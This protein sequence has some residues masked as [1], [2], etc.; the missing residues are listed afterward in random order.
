MEIEAKHEGDARERRMRRYAALATAL[1]LG[2][3]VWAGVHLA[4]QAH[5][6]WLTAPASIA[7]DVL[8]AIAWALA[9]IASAT[10]LSRLALAALGGCAA[11][12]GLGLLMSVSIPFSGVPF[13]ALGLIE[14]FAVF[15]AMP[16]FRRSRASVRQDGA[17][18]HLRAPH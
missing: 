5:Y 17:L 7:I 12:F 11:S 2:Q 9:T 4:M 3:T 13:L 14:T 10:G 1:F 18:F 15:H 8:V 6:R 16:L